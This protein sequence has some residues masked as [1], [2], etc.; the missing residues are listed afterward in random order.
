M[1]FNRLNIYKNNS[2]QRINKSKKVK[3]PFKIILMHLMIN[4][5]NSNKKKIMS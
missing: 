1:S 3:S 4:N 5:K 2:I